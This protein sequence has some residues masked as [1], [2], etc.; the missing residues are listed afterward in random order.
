MRKVVAS[1]SRRS[2]AV[3]SRCSSHPTGRPAT[4]NVPAGDSRAL[5]RE[6]PLCLRVLVAG[7]VTLEVAEWLLIQIAQ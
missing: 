6:G 5:D 7:S 2:R 4:D 3:G 1:E